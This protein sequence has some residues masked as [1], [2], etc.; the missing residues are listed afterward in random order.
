MTTKSHYTWH[1]IRQI[2]ASMGLASQKSLI[3]ADN[4]V[5]GRNLI[6]IEILSDKGGGS[7][8]RLTSID[9]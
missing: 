2:Y 9:C 1:P 6:S 3:A 5:I 4:P 7:L 8:R